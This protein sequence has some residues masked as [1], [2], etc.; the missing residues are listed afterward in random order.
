MKRRDC[1]TVI[2]NAPGK[3]GKLEYRKFKTLDEAAAYFERNADRLAGTTAAQKI[4][5]RGRG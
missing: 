4:A 1:I 5:R 3:R 2:N